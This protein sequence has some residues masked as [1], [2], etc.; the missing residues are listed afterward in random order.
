[1]NINIFNKI[2]YTIG[3]LVSI[4]FLLL[5]IIAIFSNNGSRNGPV[6]V[7]IT[8]IFLFSVGFIHCII[9]L[10]RKVVQLSTDQEKEWRKQIMRSSSVWVLFLLLGVS[11]VVLTFIFRS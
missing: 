10:N 1:V 5:L 8:G 4:V 11:A 6:I 3:L 7:P 9:G 2:I